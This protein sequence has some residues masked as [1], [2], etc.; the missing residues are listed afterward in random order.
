MGSSKKIIRRNYVNWGRGIEIL[1]YVLNLKREIE[2]INFAVTYLCNSRCYHCNIW[3]KYKKNPN[4][5]K[6]EL[7]LEEIKRGIKN[8]KFLRNLRI[9]GLTGG[10]PFLRKDFVDLCGFFIE[11]YPQAG[12][13]INT[14]AV[15]VSLIINKLE[16]IV[17][18]WDPEKISLNISLD[19]IG[20]IHDEIRGVAGNYYHVLELIKL[21]KE[22]AP[23]IDLGVSFTITPKNF[24]SLLQVYK[25]SKKLGVGFGT[26]FSQTSEFYYG[27]VE[28]KKK[29]SFDETSLDDIRASIK[30]ILMD[31][32]KRRN[33]LQKM[34]NVDAYFLSHMV[35]FQ[36]SPHQ[37]VRC[38]SGIHSIFM[39]PYGNIYPCIMLNKK[40]GNIRD[41]NFDELWVSERRRKILE[42]IKEGKCACWTP[43]ETNL[44]LW[45]SP[46]VI[47]WNLKHLL[48]LPIA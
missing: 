29:L 13:G 36:R 43:C 25:L 20:K 2:A 17:K 40:L 35:D 18:I 33:T 3:K 27:N 9:V 10:E 16:E 7:E 6:K 11:E 41:V 34:L 28:K 32:W 46:K 5:A 4:E 15:N 8:S 47:L 42:F 14:N 37:M 24:R 44:S 39:D 19:G 31:I 38:Q 22:K 45:K 26:F 30:L 12:I 23:S 48:F 21:V 1:E